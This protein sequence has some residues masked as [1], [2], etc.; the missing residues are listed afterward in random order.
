MIA[1]A[2]ADALGRIA[3][4]AQDVMRAYAGGGFPSHND[5]IAG[6]KAPEYASDPLSVV[7]PPNAYFVVQG[8]NGAR[9]FTR[10]GAFALDG[11]MLRAA[12]GATLLGY[13]GGDARGKLPVPLTLPAGDVALGRCANVRIESDGVVSYTRSTI[14]PRTAE[15]SVERVSVGKIAL[16]RFPAGTQPIR[17]DE[18]HVGAP[19]GIPAHL[20]TP[21]DGTFAGVATYARDTGSID[22]DTSLEKLSEAYRAF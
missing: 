2:T 10:D 4:R 19:Q 9:T 16:A 3:S 17:L 5:V 18:R 6:S 15:H 21:A 8:E 12:D 7:A 11:V 13:P 22:I 14:D 20:G 1:P